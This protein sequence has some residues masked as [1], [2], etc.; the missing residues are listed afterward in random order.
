[1]QRE[2]TSVQQQLHMPKLFLEKKLEPLGLLSMRSP[3]ILILGAILWSPLFRERM[4][5]VEASS[6][7]PEHQTQE[8]PNFRVDRETLNRSSY[9]SHAHLKSGA[10]GLWGIVDFMEWVSLSGRHIQK[11]SPGFVNAPLQ[12]IF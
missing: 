3:S 2:E 12:Q 1:M 10:R 5:A 7:W 11:K 9:K 8:G 6:Y 4:K